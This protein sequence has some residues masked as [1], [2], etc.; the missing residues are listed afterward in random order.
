[1]DLY[2]MS[3]LGFIAALVILIIWDRKNIDVENYVMFMR[4]TQRGRGL[5]DKIASRN[6]KFWNRVGDISTIVGIVGMVFAFIFI[7]Y[8]FSQQVAGGGAASEGPAIVLPSPT[9]EATVRP[10]VVGVPFWQWIIA[11][12]LL[13]VVH[14]GMHGIMTKTVNSK[15]NSLG[16]VL[17]AIIPGAFVEPDEEDLNQKSWR[18]RVKVYS[19]G[20]FANFCLAGATVL[21]MSFVFLPSFTSPAI[22]YAGYVN[23]TEYGLE[24]F[25]AERVNMTGDILSIGGQR[26]K[27][28]EGFLKELGKYNPGDS[29]EVQTTSDNYTLQLSENPEDTDEPFMGIAGVSEARILEDRYENTVW[30]EIINFFRELLMWIFVLNFGIGIMNLL[31]LKPLDG[32][33]IL[34]ALSDNFYPEKSEKIVRAVSSISLLLLLTALSMSFLA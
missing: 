12:L 15:I 1:M 4:R 28:S 27:S 6:K 25:P 9:G 16:L 22:G 21:F 33:L 26:V 32:G 19:A 20:S 11:I 5:I 8:I 24:T 30:G 18:D 2:F 7:G 34:E 13:L 14:E 3:F 17:F 31:P 29:L 23:A 10:G